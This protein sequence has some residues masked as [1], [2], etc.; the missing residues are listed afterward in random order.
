M[1]LVQGTNFN[2][3][4]VISDIFHQKCKQCIYMYMY[5]M[6]NLDKS[7]IEVVMEFLYPELFC[8]RFHVLLQIFK[9]QCVEM[10]T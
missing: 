10:L 8:Q 6:E 7:V 1:F 4:M 2:L 9:N 5:C 3:A